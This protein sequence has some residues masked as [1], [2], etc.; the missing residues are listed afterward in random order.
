MVEWIL[1]PVRVGAAM[2]L[3]AAYGALCA[4][5]AWQARRRRQALMPSTQGQASDVLVIY[6]SQTGQAEALALQTQQ[7]LR[8]A[9]V[10]VQLLPIGQLRW[11]QLQQHPRSLWLLSTTGEGDAPDAALPFVPL[12]GHPQPPAAGHHA[13]VLALG[14]SSYARFCAFGQQV[15][16]WLQRQQVQAEL[17]CVDRMDAR[18]LGQ[19]QQLLTRW[20]PAVQWSPDHFKP[21]I[22]RQRTH[23][24]PGSQGQAVY[25]LELVPVD[26]VLPTWEAGDVA[27][28]QVPADP[29][30]PR[31][32]S[33]AS[34]PQEGCLQLL[35]RQA[36]RADGSWGLAS[37]WLGQGLQ[38]GHT[39][40]IQLR[41]HAAFRLQGNARR[42]LILV[43]NG[44]GLAG[45]LGLLKARI[46]QGEHA[47]WLVLGERQ[48]HCDALMDAQL[49][50]WLQHGNL[51]RLDRAWSR[52]G[53]SMP[54][55]Q[56]VLLAQAEAV[57]AWVA[58][59]AAIYVSG[60]RQGM[61]DGVHAALLQI[62]GAAALQALQ[63]EHRY[64][65]DLY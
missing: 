63:A 55:V 44:T 24:N 48:A 46:A 9:S 17:I 38:L 26:G 23:L 12:L 58:Q 16:D 62:L 64:C 29:A 25:A 34:I 10:G 2:S 4:G 54:Y 30:H 52:D 6:A 33:I 51:Q 37:H 36:V 49:Q 60:S 65:R 11:E 50:T 14:D 7:A 41:A 45:L 8:L 53:G 61:G 22:L 13:A 19:W 3:L 28:I 43:G 32:Y 57:R 27:A 31:D 1:S 21:W 47:Q 39:V 35:V 56:H 5:V 15:H 18:A 42:P 59:G 20:A 40:D